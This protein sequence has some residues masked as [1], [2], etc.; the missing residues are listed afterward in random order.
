[1]ITERFAPSPTGLLHLGHAYSALLAYMSA[2]DSDGR[3][4]LRIED[5]DFNRCKPVFEEQIFSDLAWLGVEYDLP[6]L[7]QSDRLDAYQQTLKTL[8]N[9]GYLFPC[10]CTRKD[11]SIAAAPQEGGDLLVGPDG[12]VYPN[13]CLQIP[14]PKEMPDSAL[15]FNLQAIDKEEF[16][17]TDLVF[18]QV[19]FTKQDVIDEI[20]AVVLARKDIGVSYHLAVVLD[21]AFQGITHVTRG[22]DLF[23]ATKIHVVLQH[24]L[25]LPT[26]IYRHHKLIRDESGK[27]L[28]KRDD[29]RSIKSYLE[30]GLSVD[31][32]IALMD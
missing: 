24:I 15:R 32:V 1:M 8:W 20:G 6:I 10:T 30:S 9:S 14:K 3:F 17:F 22:A 21:D 7:R 28:A 12:I 27:R 25:G 5:I 11:I 18:G 31:D 4:L 23:E 19:H 16:S 2:R 13:T 26:P 29:A